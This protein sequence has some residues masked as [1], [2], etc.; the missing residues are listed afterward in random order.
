MIK[1]NCSIVELVDYWGSDL[2]VINAARVSFNKHKSILDLDDQKLIKYLAQHNHV[3][4]FEH[5]GFTFRIKT[6]IYVARQIMR[7]RSHAFN[8]ISGR[9]VKF[10]SEYFIPLEFRLQ[11]KYIKQGS[12]IDKNNQLNQDEISNIYN[13]FIE[14]A[15]NFYNTLIDKGV[16]REQARGVL[17]LCTT[18][19]FYD[20][21]NFRSFI[22]FM[23]A[24]LNRDAQKETTDVALQML[25]LV[26][27]IDKFKYS[28]EAFN[29]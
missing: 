23:G 10:E 14:T 3:S 17:P 25:N 29:L 15:F 12:I 16:C 20:T 28:L 9:Y 24:R 26:N 22:H 19:Q 1:H 21:M 8:E 11:D 27:K 18:T 2:T 13:A 5:C 7:H 4:V 6:P